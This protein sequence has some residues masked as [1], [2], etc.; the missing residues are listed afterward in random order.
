E[1]AGEIVSIGPQSA[2]MTAGEKVVVYPWIGC[3]KCAVCARGDEHLCLQA[4]FLGIHRAGGYASHVL[5]PHKRYCLPIGDL[6]PAVAAPYACSGVTTYSAL[7]KVGS[8]VLQREPI[9]VL[10]AGG[11][12]LM[13]LTLMKAMGAK[14]AIVVDI[15]PAK[16]DAAMKAGAIA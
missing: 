9:V 10:G 11:L 15:D 6:D 12:G 5:V 16:R 3:G 2:P 4:R 7:K 13:C 8:D 14:G 1:I